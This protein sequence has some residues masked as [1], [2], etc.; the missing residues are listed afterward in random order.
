VA[1]FDPSHCAAV[2]TVR[3]SMGCAGGGGLASYTLAIWILAAVVTFVSGFAAKRLP[4]SGHYLLPAFGVVA[5]MFIALAVANPTPAASTSSVVQ[6]GSPVGGAGAAQTPSLWP[7]LIGGL[8]FFYLWWLSGMLFDLAFIWRRYTRDS[9]I[10][11]HLAKLVKAEEPQPQG[12][13]RGTLG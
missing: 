5:A 2:S 11:E 3:V 12:E 9:G 10:R 4:R 8:A 13:L 7:L 6:A 1:G